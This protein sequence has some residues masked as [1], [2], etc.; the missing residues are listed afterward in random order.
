MAILLNEQIETSSQPS[1]DKPAELCFY[2]N[3]P[4]KNYPS[5]DT[6]GIVVWQGNSIVIGLH[7]PCAE[8]LGLHLIQDARSLKSATGQEAEL[9]PAQPRQLNHVWFVTKS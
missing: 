9:K 1:W 2:C 5:L 3:Q 7:Q 6:G 4:L 8:R